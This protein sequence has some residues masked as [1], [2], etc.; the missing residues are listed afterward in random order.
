MRATTNAA[1]CFA[2]RTDR[3]NWRAKQ[4]GR[5]SK[6]QILVFNDEH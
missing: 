3:T 5:Q 6:K 1:N 2:A 4:A